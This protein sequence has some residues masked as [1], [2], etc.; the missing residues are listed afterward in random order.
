MTI[1]SD[2]VD[3]IDIQSTDLISL[4]LKEYKSNLSNM[5]KQ[6]DSSQHDF[7]LKDKLVKELTLKLDRIIEEKE[8]ALELV[9]SSSTELI[10]LH[11]TLDGDF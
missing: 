5:R 1:K 4:E 6:L 9:R 11:K 10:E 3:T 8:N 7:A 2:S